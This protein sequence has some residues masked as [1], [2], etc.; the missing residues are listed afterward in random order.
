MVNLETIKQQQIDPFLK[1]VIKK[2][3]INAVIGE[4]GCGAGSTIKFLTPYQHWYGV[5]MDKEVLRKIK[6]EH[7]SEKIH[8]RYGAVSSHLDI[9]DNGCDVLFCIFKVHALPNLREAVQVLLAKAAYGGK[10]ILFDFA[11][12]AKVVLRREQHMVWKEKEIEQVLSKYRG[13]VKRQISD[14]IVAYEFVKA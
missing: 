2:L 8:V 12:T 6:A 9:P 14:Q 4:I 13:F 11:D 3:P 5:D 1:I 10:I 7:K